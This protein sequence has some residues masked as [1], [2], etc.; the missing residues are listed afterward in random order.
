MSQP[1]ANTLSTLNGNFKVVYASKERDLIPEGVK[2]LNKIAFAQKEKI[3]SSYNEMIILGMEHGMTW[4]GPD[5]DAFNLRAAVAGQSKEATIKGNPKLLRSI[6]G[7][8]SASRAA[9]G[10]QAAFVDAINYL[11]KA[12][13]KSFTRKV[14]IEMLYGTSGYAL[15]SAVDATNTILTIKESEWAA[16]IFVGGENMPLDIRSNDGATS[17]GQAKIVSVDL[18]NRLVTLGSAVPGI[19]VTSS[20]EDVIF[21]DGAYGKEFKGIHAILTQTTGDLF[22]I[23]CASYNLFRGN[24]Y[25]ASS[26]ALSFTKLNDAISRAVFKG[27]DGKVLVLVNPRTWAKLLSDQAALRLYD[28]SYSSSKMV[29]GGQSLEFHSQNGLMEIEPSIYVKQGYAYILQLD[30][31]KR[32]GSSDITFKRPGYD[33]QFFRESEN[34]SGYELRLWCD[35]ALFSDSPGL[36]V[37]ITGIVN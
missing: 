3:G 30:S 33:D 26:A 2:L 14:E 16:G 10:T 12:M 13:M 35:Q 28:S 5:E 23:P 20:S 25:S 21:H 32:I 9:N 18:D 7:L 15:I 8:T 31:W 4:G 17:R 24:T 27:L 22:G 6:L 19:V 29:N 36:N 37:V 11:V 1:S 34:I